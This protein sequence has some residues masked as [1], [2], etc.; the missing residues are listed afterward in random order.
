M[1]RLGLTSHILLRLLLPLIIG[2][3]CIT[4]I[5]LI[6]ICVQTGLL[7]NTVNTQMSNITKNSISKRIK[8]AA[9][10]ISTIFDQVNN[11]IMV[12]H[13]YSNSI[14]NNELPVSNYYKTYYGVTSIDSRIPNSDKDGFYYYSSTY[15]NG[16]NNLNDLSY[17][18][19]VNETSIMD[20][21]FRSI[22][23]SSNLYSSMYIGLSNGLFR[24]Y[25]YSNLNSYASITYICS[26]N[27]VQITGYDPTCRNWY[28]ISQNND[29]INYSPPY[30]DA[31]TSKSL[32][33]ASKRLLYSNSLVGVIGLDFD[34]SQID[35][36]VS[37]ALIINDGYNFMVDKSGQLISYPNL[38]RTKTNL[39]VFNYEPTIT[40]TIFNNIVNNINNDYLIKKND[41]DWTLSYTY[42]ND[43]YILI[44]MYP[45]S[46]LYTEASNVNIGLRNIIIIGVVILCTILIFLFVIA[47]I[48]NL[49]VG[50]KYASNIS[51]MSGLLLNITSPDLKLEDTKTYSKEFEKLKNN[52]KELRT[53]IC[54]GNNAF[55]EGNLTKA[56][57]IYNSALKIFE[58]SK[59]IKGL[60][61]CYNNIAN[62]HKQMNQNKE[63]IDLY[64]KSINCVDQLI[65]STKDND[66]INEYKIMLAN[67]YMNL[68]VLY[69]DNNNFEKAMEYF[70][71][72]STLNRETDNISGIAKVNNN[73][74]QLLLQQNRLNEAEEQINTT[75]EIIT[76]RDNVDIISLEYA[77]MAKGILEYHKGNF[78]KSIEWLCKIFDLYKETNIYIQQTCLEYLDN[79]FVTL[80]KLDTAMEIRK[81]KKQ[82]TFSKNVYFV[83]DCSGS[84]AGEPIKQ[85][86][87]SIKEIISYHLS[88]NDNI[89]LTTFDT[90]VKNIFMNLNKEINLT[91]ILS[92]ID[93]K[94]KIGSST[95][96]Y[97]ALNSSINNS[98]GLGENWIVALTDGEDNSS[99]YSPKHIT[100]LIENN[101]V[102]MIIITVGPVK[103][104]NIIKGFCQS[105]KKKGGKGIHIKS[106][107]NNGTGIAEAFNNVAKILVGQL[108]VDSII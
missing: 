5:S 88:G 100:T 32:I 25:P 33:T 28:T 54:Y 92:E 106:E 47:L 81:Y 84:M 79:A 99:K 49:L 74:G 42:I 72:S 45:T 31:L 58:R 55:F 87:K 16:I 7:F 34:M 68:G 10:Y 48:V 57:E 89:S 52:L 80:G 2:V 59:N 14:L 38:D 36:A 53:T 18:N 65:K 93:N 76:G 51:R 107:S 23:K 3:L 108:N 29:N 41:R 39:S 61:M 62:V 64:E 40:N 56:L 90:T 97:D 30:L 75:Y 17:V 96:F 13:D 82:N 101:L 71:K 27:N 35:K 6:P 43:N 91:Q 8:N 85:C 20:N 37:G 9:N 78:Q 60:S 77:I 50:Y 44:T 1:L 104:E 69:K 86:Q 66:R 102:N 4:L 26:S 22:Y 21:I 83:L 24:R 11:D 19:Y 12:V 63:A 98:K 103:T 70:N 105:C 46:G 15:K 73:I 67:R 95:A 94:V